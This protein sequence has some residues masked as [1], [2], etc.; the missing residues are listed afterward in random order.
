[1]KLY[2]NS[3]HYWL[4]TK[5]YPHTVPTNLC[6]YFWKVV[7]AVI[8]FPFNFLWNLPLEIANLINKGGN[9]NKANIIGEPHYYFSSL[10]LANFIVYFLLY[11]IISMICIWIN[12]D[13]RFFLGASLGYLALVAI[14]IVALVGW[15]KDKNEGKEKSPNI[16]V[17]FV[18][19]KY[20]K[21]CPQITWIKTKEN[22]N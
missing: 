8:C 14:G 18:K 5:T 10:W 4:Y 17:E 21:Y 15:L 12:Y 20:S 16:L 3:W 9:K 11:V 19:A 1:M 7:F 2:D 13:P 22:G 6:P